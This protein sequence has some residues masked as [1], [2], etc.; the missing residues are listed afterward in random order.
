MS[1]SGPDPEFNFIS[2]WQ[3]ATGPEMVWDAL[4]DFRS[5]PD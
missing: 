5:W 1:V 4:V 2:R 3:L